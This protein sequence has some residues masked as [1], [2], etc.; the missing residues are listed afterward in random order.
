M[1]IIK[2]SAIF[3]YIPGSVYRYLGTISPGDNVVAKVTD[4]FTGDA[5]DNLLVTNVVDTG[6]SGIFI[7]SPVEITTEKFL[8][9][10]QVQQPV[11][12]TPE[13]ESP[14]EETNSEDSEAQ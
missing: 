3:G 6:V 14:G 7:H 5:G 2:L 9:L 11:V 1:D 13:E 12:A 10:G 8:L 4:E